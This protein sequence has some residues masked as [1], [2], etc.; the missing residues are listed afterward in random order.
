MSENQVETQ[1]SEVAVEKKMTAKDAALSAALA[2]KKMGQF[3]TVT[4]TYADKFL[5]YLQSDR[6]AQML[7]RGQ[8][9]AGRIGLVGLYLLAVIFVLNIFLLPLV[10]DFPWGASMSLGLGLAV[11]ALVI[12]YVN[13]KMLPLLEELVS[14]PTRVASVGFLNAVSVV[15]LFAGLF[16]LIVYWY[17]GLTFEHFSLLFNGLGMAIG[18]AVLA[19]LVINYQLLG[20][21]VVESATAGDSFICLISLVL[22]AYIKLIPVVFMGIV[23]WAIYSWASL[24]FERYVRD[25]HLF[26]LVQ[27]TLGFVA[28]HWLYHLFVSGSL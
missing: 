15:L 13:F 9:F 19:L 11:G 28:P 24:P 1:A 27:V 25:R 12:H 16:G 22:K 17:I 2:L 6:R 4:A 21:E 7:S 26:E 14:T 5:N 8:N 20:I 18:C 3:E 10:H 23:F